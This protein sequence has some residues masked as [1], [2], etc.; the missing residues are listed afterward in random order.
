MTKNNNE[1]FKNFTKYWIWKKSYKK[2]EMKAKDHDH[3]TEKY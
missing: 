3:I 1:D 2:G